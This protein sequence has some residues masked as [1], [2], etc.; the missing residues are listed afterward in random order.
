MPTICRLVQLSPDD[1]AGLLAAPESLADRVQSATVR[2]DVD[3]YWHAI[4]YLLSRH[5]P[6]GAAARWLTAGAILP[7]AGSDLPRSRLL[8]PD[9]VRELAA[10]LRDI[11]PDELAP[12]YDA[13]ALD[14]A[15]VYPEMWQ[16]WEEDFDP[17][18]QVLEHYWFLHQ[19]VAQCADT[20]GGLLLHFEF[21][22]DG[23]V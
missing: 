19:A 4:G 7:S 16:A 22:A 12:P 1:A 23:A 17:L 2:G 3:R 10:D 15:R 9:Q 5:R 21:L 13:A 8:S 18:G 20:G 6:D 14:A 11:P